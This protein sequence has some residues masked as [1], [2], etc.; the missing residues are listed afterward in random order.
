MYVTSELLKVQPVR[1]HYNGLGGTV[2]DGKEFVGVI[3]QDVEKVLPSMVSSRQAKLH[4]TDDETT[5]IKQ[6][7]PRNFTYL[8]INA[9]KEQQKVIAKQEAR[10]E[11][12]EQG[13]PPLASS[14]F[15]LRGLEA[16]MT[17]GL[18]PFG[19]VMALRRRRKA[20]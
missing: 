10:I 5:G 2:D 14:V 19:F 16:G 8:L 20:G 13:R 9:V 7:D 18:V 11:A 4:P 15:P 3:A 17:I 6:V 12:L 1:F